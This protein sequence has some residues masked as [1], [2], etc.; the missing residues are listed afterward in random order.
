MAFNRQECSHIE[1]T[2][3]WTEWGL[4]LLVWDKNK[5]TERKTKPVVLGRDVTEIHLLDNNKQLN[6]TQRL[7]ALAG[8]EQP[9]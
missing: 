3:N 9:C 5:K 6:A 2:I 4:I 1:K 7:A 8:G